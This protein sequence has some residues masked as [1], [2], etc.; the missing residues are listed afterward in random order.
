[1]KVFLS[2]DSCIGDLADLLG[3]E[4]TIPPASIVFLVERFHQCQVLH[5]DESEAKI[6]QVLKVY[7]EVEEVKSSEVRSLKVGPESLLSEL[8]GDVFDHQRSSAVLTDVIRFDIAL[9]R[10]Q[11]P[12]PLALVLLA[13]EARCIFF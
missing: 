2:L 3:I 5:I 4:L 8:V 1:L 11:L 6:A 12:F 10:F 13:F 9:R 7:G